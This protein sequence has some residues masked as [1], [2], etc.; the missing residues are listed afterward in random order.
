VE[1]WN[2]LAAQR[3]QHDDYC[4]VWVAP[5]R[6]VAVLAVTNQGGAAQAADEAVAAMVRLQE[7][8]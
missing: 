8:R 5:L 2:G 4:V 3:Q 7:K 6:D 1:R